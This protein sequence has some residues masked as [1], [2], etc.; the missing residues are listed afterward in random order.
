M[1]LEKRNENAKEREYRLLSWRILKFALSTEFFFNIREL[2][3]FLELISFF[4]TYFY[5]KHSKK[6]A[7]KKLL[8][9][10]DSQYEKHL[11]ITV[12][13]QDIYD[14]IND[15]EINKH[16][17]FQRNET[18]LYERKFSLKYK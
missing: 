10:I 1:K 18:V 8:K 15:F 7:I 4:T 12:S 17:L 2:K 5:P 16:F 3:I 11:E 13:Q 9:K 6:E 14:Y